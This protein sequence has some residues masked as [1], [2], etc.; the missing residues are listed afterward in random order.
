MWLCFKVQLPCVSI[1]VLSRHVP[2][3]DIFLGEGS[4]ILGRLSQPGRGPGKCSAAP[5]NVLASG[6]KGL[7]CFAW[8]VE[9]ALSTMVAGLVLG[10]PQGVCVR[11]MSDSSQEF[12]RANVGL[13][14]A[15][16]QDSFLRQMAG[17]LVFLNSSCCSCRA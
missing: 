16:S 5:V 11:G 4:L 15:Y 13:T 6:D 3:W 14:C 1:H 10:L 7:V 8:G 2:A 9:R 17:V 12:F